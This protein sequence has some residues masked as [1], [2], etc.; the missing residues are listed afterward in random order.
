MVHPGSDDPIFLREE[1]L[2]DT[3]WEKRARGRIELISYNSL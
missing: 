2:M 3:P 1:E